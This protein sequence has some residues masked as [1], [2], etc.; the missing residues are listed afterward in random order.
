MY[1]CFRPSLLWEYKKKK[2]FS[3]GYTIYCTKFLGIARTTI[4]SHVMYY[5][6]QLLQMDSYNIIQKWALTS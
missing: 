4:L 1:V 6:I 2:N 5:N 3:K